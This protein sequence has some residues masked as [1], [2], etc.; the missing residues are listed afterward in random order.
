MPL[1]QLIYCSRPQIPD[2]DW[3]RVVVDIFETARRKNTVNDITGCLSY[4]PDWFLQVLEGS[5]RKVEA[6]YDRI[7]RDGRHTEIKT[8]ISQPIGARSFPEWSMAS[9][10]R[11]TTANGVLAG[12]GLPEGFSPTVIAPSVLM[13]ALK[14]VADQRRMNRP[15]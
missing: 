11:E 7:K 13:M 3:Q 6:T 9:V 5:T 12:S 14:E 15:G 2:A 4:G 8:L 10:D 1:T